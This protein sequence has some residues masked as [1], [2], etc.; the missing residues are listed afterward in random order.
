M[1][2]EPSPVHKNCVNGEPSPVHSPYAYCEN[3]PVRNI[4][5]DGRFPKLW[6]AKVNHIF[7][8]MEAKI[9][10]SVVGDIVYDRNA[11]TPEGRY[12]YNKV[13]S[14]GEGG[15]VVT[16]VTKMSRELADNVSTIGTGIEGVGYVM[17]LSVVGAEVNHRDRFLIP[18]AINNIVIRL[19]HTPTI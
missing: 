18:R 12:Y 10:G 13:S 15:F 16:K 5:P 8:E 6:Q 14:D 1:N 7:S 4:D 11:S 3:N 9:M 2:G 19:N 17:T